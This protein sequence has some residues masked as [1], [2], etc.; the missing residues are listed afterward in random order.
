[1]RGGILWSI[2]ATACFSLPVGAQSKYVGVKVCAECHGAGEKGG[3]FHA[4]Q[5]SKHAE[6]YRSLVTH[7]ESKPRECQGLNLWVVE[8]GRGAKY[9][10]PKPAMQARECIPC[11]TAAFGADASLI[12]P[13]FDPKDGVQCEACHGPGSAHADAMAANARDGGN[14]R[15]GFRRAKDESAIKA[16]CMG[17]HEGTCGDF[18]FAAMWPA[19]RHSASRPN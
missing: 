12:A 3:A 19:I 13:S 2:A 17:C 9:G 16:G 18:D 1:M 5:K 11:H 15:A 7:S 8:I 6:A 10:L 14:R 4:W